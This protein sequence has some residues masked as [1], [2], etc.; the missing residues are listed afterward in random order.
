MVVTFNCAT[1][2]VNKIIWKQIILIIIIMGLDARKPVFGVSDEARLNPVPSATG[3]SLKIEIS[4]VASLD[5]ILSK[6][7]NNKGA[8]QFVRMRRL[9]CAFVF[10]QTTED[11][12]S[13]VKRKRKR[14]VNLE[15]TPRLTLRFLVKF[16]CFFVVW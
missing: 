11:R 4:L 9:V 3:T 14:R 8:E 12:F 2:L 5:L 10:S 13:R 1:K 15:M 6:G 7:A 16:A